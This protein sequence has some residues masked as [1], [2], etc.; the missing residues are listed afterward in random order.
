MRSWLLNST[1]LR[2]PEGDGAA[3]APVA[4]TTTTPPASTESTP[5]QIRE[6][7]DFDP[8]EPAP[9]A[10]QEGEVKTA[11]TPAPAGGE[12]KKV[13]DAQVPPS[14]AEAAPAKPD[15]VAQQ[16]EQVANLLRQQTEAAARPKPAEA[17]KGAKAPKFNLSIPESISKALLSSEEPTE[18]VAALT[19]FANGLSNLVHEEIMKEVRTNLAEIVRRIPEIAGNQ[20][21]ELTTQ[22]EMQNDFWNAASG[23]HI[24]EAMRLPRSKEMGQFVALT[25]QSLA[26]ELKAQGKDLGWTPEFRNEV[27]KRVCTGLGR[28]VPSAA[29]AQPQ[30][31]NGN[32]PPRQPKPAA[33]ATGQGGRGD[34]VTYKSDLEKDIAE[35]FDA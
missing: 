16:L 26:M 30:R 21:R 4:D 29:P 10:G 32:L 19:E 8:F 31:P 14:D 6:L 11:A 33:F 34:Q 24:P 18:R 35:M 17:E 28:A 5:S 2:A 12:K 27:L 1:A 3:P 9:D 22:Q 25:A 7:L 13:G 23:Q 15:P 20:V